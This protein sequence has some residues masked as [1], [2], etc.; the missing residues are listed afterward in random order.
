MR[1][2]LLSLL[3]DYSRSL[4]S[5]TYFRRVLALLR[6]VWALVRDD[7]PNYSRGE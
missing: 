7:T 1:F 5:C 4:W 2:V 3:F 6:G